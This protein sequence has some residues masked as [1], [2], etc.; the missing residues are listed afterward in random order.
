M[1][2]AKYDV[3]VVGAGPAG[4]LAAI[5]A[6]KGGAKTLLLEKDR[7]IGYPVRCAEGVS[8]IG[9]TNY[10]PL[11]TR[12]VRST[13]RDAVLIAP[14]ATEVPVATNNEMGYI[15]DRRIFDYDLA[16]LAA[17]EGVEVQTKSYVY[18]L[19]KD[20]KGAVSGVKVDYLGKNIDIAAKIVIGADG[21]ESRVG[22]W[23]GLRTAVKIKDMESCAQFTVSGIEI[24]PGKIHFYFGENWAP[25][26]YLWLFPK[27]ENL[28]NIGLG[29]NGERTG[30]RCALNL[31][32]DFLKRHYPNASILTT[33]A[34]GVPVAKTLKQITSDGLMLVGDAARTVNPISG[35]GI[36]TGML[37]GKLAGEVAAKA[38]QKGDFT[39][40]FLQNYAKNW[41]KAQ[42]KNHERLY[43]VKEVIFRLTDDEL[44][45]LAA[46][47]IQIPLAE[48]SLLR[49]FKT[50]FMN[51]PALLKDILLAIAGF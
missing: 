37:S 28:A 8:H 18:D 43:R 40:D 12:W 30:S 47:V 6:A 44:N 9:L 33:V 20:E 22:R 14:D 21:V 15:L 11:N 39:N 5:H 3:I 35:G 34:G 29:V 36:A 46:K 26:G 45:S 23:A 41:H 17:K 10:V 31:L 2:Q 49:I 13:I 48:R 32:N 50:L 4:S 16:M 19:L 38:L 27:G 7:D 42:G 24:D 1:N 51:R 25:G